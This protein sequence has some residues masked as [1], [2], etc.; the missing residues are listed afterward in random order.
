MVEA[1]VIFETHD[2]VALYLLLR[3]RRD[4]EKSKRLRVFL[5]VR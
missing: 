5:T 1:G 4:T 3:R 2:S